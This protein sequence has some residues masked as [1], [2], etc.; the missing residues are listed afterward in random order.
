MHNAW[1]RQFRRSRL[2][3]C[4]QRLKCFPVLEIHLCRL[5]ACCNSEN[6]VLNFLGHICV[7]WWQW[8]WSWWCIPA[9][10]ISSSTMYWFWEP[11][12]SQ[13]H[14]VSKHFMYL[15]YLATFV[16]SLKKRIFPCHKQN[17][18][19]NPLK[20]VLIGK[21]HDI[22]YMINDYAITLL[23]FHWSS[24]QDSNMT[25]LCSCQT[26]EALLLALSTVSDGLFVKHA[27]SS[28]VMPMT[29]QIGI[30]PDNNCDEMIIPRGIES[31]RSGGLGWLVYCWSG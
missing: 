24:D 30:C 1:I 13:R 3:K 9:Q 10:N 18:N 20:K 23:S 25:C 7:S 2:R 21:Q 14:L 5:L 17:A 29:T 12:L 26:K 6:P 11:G 22:W 4:K 15:L 19:Q 28:S 8:R 16:Y 27:F 31:R